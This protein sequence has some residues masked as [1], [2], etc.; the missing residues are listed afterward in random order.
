MNE[1]VLFTGT[2]SVHLTGCDQ[3][4]SI[5]IHVQIFTIQDLAI[6][7]GIGNPQ[8]LIFISLCGVVY[9]VSSAKQFYGAGKP[10]NVYAGRE[11]GRALG[12][13]SPIDTP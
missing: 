12:A 7:N 9:D 6:F 1:L 3:V 11:S 10:Y 5:I 2:K 13:D 8:G 4:T